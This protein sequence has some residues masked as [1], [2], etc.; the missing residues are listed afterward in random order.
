MSLRSVTR[1]VDVASGAHDGAIDLVDVCAE[2]ATELEAV[3]NGDRDH[4]A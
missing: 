2:V 3:V 1:W 4:T